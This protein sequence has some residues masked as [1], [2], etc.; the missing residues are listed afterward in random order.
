[1]TYSPA[2]RRAT[3]V[4]LA[5][6]SVALGF[7][8]YS[9]A[10]GTGGTRLAGSMLLGFWAMAALRVGRAVAGSGS[11]A[12]SLA[13][14]HL[15]V[16]ASVLATSAAGLLGAPALS[17]VHAAG[18]LI[19][20]R[21]APRRETRSAREW[22]SLLR[23][24]PAPGLIVAIALLVAAANASWGLLAPEGR[25]D[26]LTYHLVFPAA[27]LQDGSLTVLEVP[28]GNHSPS[29]H[30]KSSEAVFAWAIAPFRELF[31]V[32]AVQFV[33]LALT[34]LTL[35]EVFRRTGASPRAAATAAPLFALSPVVA[36]QAL[37]GYV[38]V[39]FG[40]FLA[41]ALRAALDLRSRP[42]PRA[43]LELCAFTGVFAG[44]KMLGLPLTVVVVAPAFVAFA[45]PGLLRR[46]PPGK[47]AVGAV[48][49]AAV[50]LAFG[51]WWYVRNWMMTGN[52]VFPLL[53]EAGGRV[54]LDGAYVNDALP[55]SRL[56]SLLELVPTPV[57]F[58]FA[59][60]ALVTVAAAVRRTLRTGA[61]DGD[62][63]PRRAALIGVLIP[64]A[65][66]TLFARTIPLDQERFLVILAGLAAGALTVP[67]QMP[68]AG[69]AAEW[70]V[71]GVVVL[72][73]ALPDERAR[74][75]MPPEARQ[76][77][78]ASAD[79]WRGFALTMTVLLGAVVL[80]AVRLRP[81][82]AGALGV[83]W[84]AVALLAV[85]EIAVTSDPDGP[86]AH[87]HVQ[88]LWEGHQELSELGRGLR[89]AATGKP[90]T[91]P[92]Y[93][94]DLS[95]RVRYVDVND[96]P[97]DLFHDHVRRWP[98]LREELRQDRRGVGYYRR[99]ASEATWLENIEAYAPDVLVVSPLPNHARE[100]A[101]VRD[102]QGFPRERAWADG[103][104]ETFRPI[105]ERRT[106]R[107]YDLRS[108]ASLPA[109]SPAAAPPPASA[110]A[111]AAPASAAAGRPDVILIVTDTTR[112]DA[113]GCY[114]SPRDNTPELDR[115]ASENVRFDRAIATSPWTLPSVASMLTSRM[116]T[117]HGAYR[118]L[119]D[120]T[121]VREGVVSGVE[122]LR[123]LG[124]R[125]HGIANAVFLG[126][127]FGLDRGFDVY[128]FQPADAEILR[129]AGECVDLALS[130]LEDGRGSPDFL[131][132]HVFD[133]HMPYDPPG[134]FRRP[135][136]GA[137]LR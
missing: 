106:V 104:A 24:N 136:S 87:R 127:E 57:A 85:R 52:P 103:H 79:V 96:T 50:F 99:D 65:L 116:P 97:G 26:D 42:G 3:E 130:A 129:R 58:L 7:Y 108:R 122:V 25:I 53:V 38:D 43:W 59:A 67:L 92:F 27:W 133:P 82:A 23:R 95:N 10:P 20:G 89:V 78:L 131:L 15:F 1:M 98:E 9:A 93:G 17:V 120:Y 137:S 66:A 11:F 41:L 111:A 64:V 30:P 18:F 13:Y 6:A 73:L 47:L 33:W 21:F 135:R 105:V 124:Y 56:S 4:A 45:L 90:A 75:L 36:D 72:C 115:F 35:H 109:R 112:R 14:A 114:G 84:S 44:T 49:G 46:Y 80:A 19:A 31:P 101:Y 134:R 132:L 110:P 68:R 16:L 86:A 40:L 55:G 74:F 63:D 123:R 117:V 28:F 32:A 39:A 121:E 126:P 34:V 77:L 81:A 12:R 119:D 37:C 70:V 51:G 128:D 22:A 125:T 91:L 118:A 88:Q 94:P 113:F 2:I 61:A 54:L 69:K 60:G 62:P 71:L 102:D 29:Y 5:S 8:V 83:A 100:G 107:I 76:L 48:T